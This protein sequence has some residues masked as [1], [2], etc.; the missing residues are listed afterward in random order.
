[1]GGVTWIAT[2]PT[3]RRLGLLTR[4][5]SAHFADMA[6]RGEVVSGLGASEG[7]IYGRFGYGPATSVVSFGV[8]RAH[9]T[10]AA[11]LDP[12]AAGRVTLLD[13]GEAAVRLPAIYD[14]LRHR[15]PGAVTRSPA[16]WQSY[17][18]DPPLERG[19]ATRMFH[20]VHETVAGTADGYV[21][22]RVKAEFEGAT[23]LNAVHVV[24]VLAAD[25]G[26]YRALWRF[27]LDT[28]LCH[29]VSCERGRVEEPLRWLL[30][31]PRRFKVDEL[32][33]FLW[34]RLLDVPRALAARRYAAAGQVVLEITDPFPAR[35]IKRYLLR[36]APA[37]RE[38]TP[39]AASTLPAE[40]APTSSDP[41]LVLDTGVL[42]SAYL[43]GVSFATLAAAGRLRELTPGAVAVADAMFM[44][45]AAPFCATEF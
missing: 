27:V 20:V 16:M 38:A 29:T 17:L 32:F 28:D 44:T 12:V 39:G 13:D 18:A 11:P 21:T 24:E 22:Y 1:M 7:S 4:L 45:G 8:E 25:P 26:V 35:S 41:D 33:D 2:S 36:V 15:Q 6:Q 9:A 10:F 43:G 30:S 31:D 19:G 34:L 42:A 3:H 5:M 40:C 14:S 23:A 37:A